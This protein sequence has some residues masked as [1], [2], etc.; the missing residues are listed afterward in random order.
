MVEDGLVLTSALPRRPLPGEPVAI[1]TPALACKLNPIVIQ[2]LK[3]KRL[4][5]APATQEQLDGKCR[6]VKLRVMW[7][8]TVRRQLLMHQGAPSLQ[9][10][11]EPAVHP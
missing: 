1:L 10:A 5:D 9:R 11:V 3:A 4:P 7:P 2:P 8:P 6:P